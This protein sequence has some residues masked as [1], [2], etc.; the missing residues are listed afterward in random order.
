M[1]WKKVIGLEDYYEVSDCGHVK[2]LRSNKIL[3]QR[4]WGGYA[5]VRLQLLDGSTTTRSVHRLMMETFCPLENYDNMVVNHIDHDK[6]NNTLANLEWMT[7]EE[8]VR[9]AYSAGLHESKHKGGNNKRAVKCVET[10]KIYESAA[11]AARAINIKSTGKIG[12][13]IKDPHKTCG[14]FHWVRP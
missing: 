2:S 11:A 6:L 3:S 10:G 1:I 8:N 7:N 4:I 12:D 13:A 5:T 14:G 9:E